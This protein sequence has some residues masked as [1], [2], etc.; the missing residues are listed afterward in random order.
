M[1]DIKDYIGKKYAVQCSSK[2]EWQK[3]MDLASHLLDYPTNRFDES[4]TK[5][6]SLNRFGT[7]WGY[8][9]K[10]QIEA[11]GYKILPASDFLGKTKKEM[12]YKGDYI[13]TL[14]VLDGYN[15]ARKNYCFKQRID[16]KAI[17]PEVDLQGSRENGHAVMSFDKNEYLKDWRYATP[18]EIAEYERIGK[19]YDV[20]TLHKQPNFVVGKWYKYNNWYIKYSHEN[21]G[22]FISSEEI[23][24][25]KVHEYCKSPF[26][27]CDSKKIEL[28]DLTEI[29]QY[30]PEGHPDKIKPMK[31]K[32]K[33]WS[34]GT[35]VVITGQYHSTKIGEVHKLDDYQCEISVNISKSVGISCLPYKS[36]CKWFATKEEADEFAK[37]LI[38][39]IEKKS[40]VGRYLKALVD[41][42]FGFSVK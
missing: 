38:K 16:N 29:Q 21:K 20:T 5:I 24:P 3:I 8:S 7:Y 33:E 39:P 41:N 27:E 30:L 17:Y 25:S 42:P 36:V 10:E 35:Y 32:V 28:T 15:C 23:S 1:K 26:G 19:P 18:E 9:T 2:E 11:E 22:T 12:F 37:T 34:E 6:I 14:D 13:V 4:L 31:N 40:L